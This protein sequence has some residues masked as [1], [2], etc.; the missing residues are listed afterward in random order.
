MN[1]KYAPHAVNRRKSTAGYD[2]EK[3]R[4]GVKMSFDD[5]SSPFQD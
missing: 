3:L 1:S 4:G 2:I 5:S